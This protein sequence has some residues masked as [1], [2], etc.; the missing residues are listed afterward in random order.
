MSFKHKNNK[1]A[2]YTRNFLRQLIPSIYF[3]KKYAN[4]LKNLK[5]YDEK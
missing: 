2:Y 4:K 3:Q 1:I 5:Y